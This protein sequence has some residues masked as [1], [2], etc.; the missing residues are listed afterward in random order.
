MQLRQMNHALKSTAE[1]TAQTLWKIT[2]R[3][4]DGYQIIDLSSIIYVKANDSY[5]KIYLAHGQCYLE[6]KNLNYFE[7]LLAGKGFWRTHKSYIINIHHLT[8]ILKVL[9]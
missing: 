2:V 1:N 5:S 3:V 4:S 7:N 6:S 9:R 8:R